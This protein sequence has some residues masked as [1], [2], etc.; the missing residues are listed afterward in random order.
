MATQRETQSTPPAS[1]LPEC[2]QVEQE[3]EDE[4]VN[5]Y[6][7]IETTFTSDFQQSNKTKAGLDLVKTNNEATSSSVMNG[8]QSVS[9]IN[10]RK[11]ESQAESYGDFDIT[12][13]IPSLDSY[14]P[15]L[16]DILP[17][18]LREKARERV[19]YL[20]EKQE[21]KVTN[22][23]LANFVLASGSQ[24]RLQEEENEE[25]NL[26]ECEKCKQKVSAF[27]LPEHLDWHFAVNLSK[28]PNPNALQQNFCL[29]CFTG[30]CRCSNNHLF[31]DERCGNEFYTKCTSLLQNLSSS[32]IGTIDFEISDH[33]LALLVG[34]PLLE[35]YDL[36][37]V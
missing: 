18:R 26:V 35:L 7:S 5:S 25:D 19:K 6:N 27:T 16:L 31:N 17:Q 30:V 28:Q 32:Y 37:A 1:P 8:E 22:N 34:A 12:D 3:E 23:A 14:D 13:L 10:E 15:S 29:A 4:N 2:D 36:R 9:D 24:I 11:V 21:S 20:K 33:A